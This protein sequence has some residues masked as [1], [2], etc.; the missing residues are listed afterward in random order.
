MTPRRPRVRRRDLTGLL[1][2]SGTALLASG[3]NRDPGPVPTSSDIPRDPLAQ[4][5]EVRWDG[6]TAQDVLALPITD[7]ADEL[8]AWADLGTD[9]ATLDP[10]RQALVTFLEASYLSPRVLSD[11]DAAE[12]FTHVDAST[13]GYWH[14]L[15]QTAW[16]DGDRH[17]YAFALA[18]PFATVGRPAL[19]MDWFRAERDSVPV[20]QLGGTIAWSVVDTQTHAVGVIAYQLGIVADIDLRGEAGDAGSATSASIRVS[21]HGLD[22]CGLRDAD[23]LVAPA[24]TDTAEHRA[25]QQATMDSVIASPRIR[26]EDVL[27]LESAAFSAN[28]ATNILCD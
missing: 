24:L 17:L 7:S 23:G 22:G 5:D 11:L 10:T 16:D 4:L 27:D 28:D 26:P 18:E 1:A 14:D 9:D 3:C 25:A 6:R 21:I 8:N 2:L 20:L 12:T 13:P 15:L 19:A